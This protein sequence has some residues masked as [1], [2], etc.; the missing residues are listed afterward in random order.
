MARATF[1][2]FGAI[3]LAFVSTKMNSVD[4][5]QVLEN[6]LLPHYNRF[7]QKSF[8]FQEDNPVVHLSCSTMNWFRRRNIVLMDWTVSE[9]W[10]KI[11]PAILRNLS[12][13]IT[14]RIEM[15]LNSK[16]KIWILQHILKFKPYSTDFVD[17]SGDKQVIIGGC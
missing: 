9:E 10:S 8:I 3:E 4:Y 13:N 5:Q 15:L 1:S 6:H 12:T 14:E 2:S 17:N 16:V 11:D 7:P